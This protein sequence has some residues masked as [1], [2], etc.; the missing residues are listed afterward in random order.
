MSPDPTGVHHPAV[1]PGVTD[2][3]WHVHCPAC[4]DIAGQPVERCLVFPEPWPSPV[5]I[6]AEVLHW[7]RQP[8]EAS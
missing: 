5:L 6:G 3:E 1:T 4:E 8:R 2:A 7:W